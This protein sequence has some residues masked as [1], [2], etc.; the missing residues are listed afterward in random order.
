MKVLFQLSV[1]AALSGGAAGSVLHVGHHVE[2][3]QSGSFETHPI[4]WDD[5]K[6][7]SVQVSV[8]NPQQSFKLTLSNDMRVALPTIGDSGICT[9]SPRSLACSNSAFL[10]NQSSTFINMT[11]VPTTGY[12]RGTFRDDFQ[13]GIQTLRNF[14]L[15]ND[16]TPYGQGRLG[17]GAPN[18]GWNKTEPDQGGDSFLLQM[19]VSQFIATPAYSICLHWMES[20]GSYIRLSSIIAESPTGR[21][22]I[23]PNP[24]LLLRLGLEGGPSIFPQELAIAAWAVA[25]ATWLPQ[26]EQAA[27]PCAMKDSVGNFTLNLGGASGVKI[28]VP[29]RLLVGYDTAAG[30]L[31]TTN[32][33]G[34]PMCIFGILNGTDPRTYT[35]SASILRAVYLV[36]DSSNSQVAIAQAQHDGTQPSNI[37][38]FS[39]SAAPI[40]SATKAPDQEDP[41]LSTTWPSVPSSTSLSPTSATTTYAAASGFQILSH[42]T[43]ETDAIGD[44]SGLS[45]SAKIGIGVGTAA[46]VCILTGVFFAFRRYHRRQI[47]SRQH[48]PLSHGDGVKLHA[49]NSDGL[50]NGFRGSELPSDGIQIPAQLSHVYPPT[51][52]VEGERLPPLAYP[53]E[54]YVEPGQAGT[55]RVEHSR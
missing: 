27:V 44:T 8:G 16:E 17:L 25:G 54:L 36:V 12:Q 42:G 13:L 34:D 11:N 35:I 41:N 28:K 29:M 1:L 39:G 30:R 50:S 10:G 9:K 5:V 6:G 4:I 40:P 37:V 51:S 20:G 43:N 48:P 32:D 2:S 45:Q 49:G 23:H 47:S 24:G 52:E 53:Q 14:S 33:A 26:Q 15:F 31:N 3:R 55:V 18:G 38:P 19:A 46:G 7:Y 22:I 21:D